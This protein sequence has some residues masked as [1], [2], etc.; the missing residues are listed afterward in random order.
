MHQYVDSDNIYYIYSPVFILWPSHAIEE[1]S[2]IFAIY[3]KKQN[4]LTEARLL[5]TTCILLWPKTQFDWLYE[6]WMHDKCPVLCRSGV[7][8]SQQKLFIS[9]LITSL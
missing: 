4:Y 2:A 8:D 5:E 3:F 1:L 9:A 7:C 6:I